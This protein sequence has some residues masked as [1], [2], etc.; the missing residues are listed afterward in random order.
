MINLKVMCITAILCVSV[1]HGAIATANTAMVR[2]ATAIGVGLK[3]SVVPL[4]NGVTTRAQGPI[5]KHVKKKLT[6]KNERKRAQKQRRRYVLLKRNKGEG[7]VQ[8]TRF[9]TKV[10]A[11]ASRGV[12]RTKYVGTNV[13]HIVMKSTPTGERSRVYC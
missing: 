4:R 13:Q 3:V 10:S 9:K 12:R 7:W 11:C 1:G 2:A 6:K 5:A 8:V